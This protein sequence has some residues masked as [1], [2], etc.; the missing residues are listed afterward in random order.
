MIL[1]AP[2]WVQ[3]NEFVLIQ[4]WIE[5]NN[6]NWIIPSEMKEMMMKD[7]PKIAPFQTDKDFNTKFP[8]FR[9]PR[10]EIKIKRDE[11]WRE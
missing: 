5:F 2:E 11:I 10:H 8:N 6:N 9:P 3:I 1:K 7:E 4:T